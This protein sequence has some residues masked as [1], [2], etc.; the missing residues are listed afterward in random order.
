MRG[1]PGGA[2]TWRADEALATAVQ[3]EGAEAEGVPA[4]QQGVVSTAEMGTIQHVGCSCI[5]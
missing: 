5:Y 1:W 3:Q 4:S 2:Y